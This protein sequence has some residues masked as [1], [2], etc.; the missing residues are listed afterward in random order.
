[1]DKSFDDTIVTADDTAL[2][3]TALTATVRPPSH[4]AEIIATS[5]F[6]PA[7]VHAHA[8]QPPRNLIFLPPRAV[9]MSGQQFVDKSL[10]LTALVS[11][12][13]AESP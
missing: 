13:R 2:T 4:P 10:G 7:P 5:F 1:M 3:A 6:T 11:T 9:G 12:A 8:V